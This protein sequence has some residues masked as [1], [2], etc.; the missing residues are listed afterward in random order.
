[1]L[2]FYEKTISKS[3]SNCSLA[4]VWLLQLTSYNNTHKIGSQENMVSG[5]VLIIISMDN[6]ISSIRCWDL[7]VFDIEVSSCAIS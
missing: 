4:S 3:L 6:Q 7:A 5:F 2:L 1:M